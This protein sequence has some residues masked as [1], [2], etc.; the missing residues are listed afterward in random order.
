MKKTALVVLAL[1]AFGALAAPALAGSRNDFKVIQN[2]VKRA[3]DS[4]GTGH[5][6]R[7]FKVAIRDSHAS[8][9]AVKITLPIALIEI[10]LASSDDGRHFKVDDEACEIDLRAVWSALKKAGPQ[11]LVEIRGDDGAVF[12]VWLE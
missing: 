5:G 9:A 2:A 4:H 3:P 6:P 11:A 10:V 8:R 12:K 1:F 7:W